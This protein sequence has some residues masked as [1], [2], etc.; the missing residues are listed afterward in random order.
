MPR[1]PDVVLKTERLLLC[2]PKPGAG[3]K[4]RR[5]YEDT[6]EFHKRW[7]PPRPK[8]FL[9]DDYWTERLSLA[10]LEFQDGKSLRL[11]LFL[12]SDPDGPPV[13][14]ANF[15]AFVRG[16]FQACRLG[17]GLGEPFEGKGYMTE[18]LREALR[19]I[20]DDLALH[21]VEANY[22]PTNTRSGTLL[23]RLGFSVN[24]YARDYLYINGA[25]RDHVL[26]S[27]T[28]PNSDPPF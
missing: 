6:R 27:L 16:S 13:G 26:T 8:S 21:R 18:A 22:V 4:L 5:Y 14:V 9:T 1:S 25:W 20:F 12:A 28:S 11:V 2:L 24:G 7:D 17:Y 10:R 19:Y 23:R 3:P 15:T